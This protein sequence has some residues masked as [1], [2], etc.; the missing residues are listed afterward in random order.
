[1]RRLA[2]ALALVLTACGAAGPPD[3]STDEAVHEAFAA[4]TGNPPHDLYVTR[5]VELPGIVLV[6]TLIPDMG[7]TPQGGFVAGVWHDLDDL[8]GPALAHLGWVGVSGEERSRIALLWVRHSQRF[9]ALFE[10]PGPML[11]EPFVEPSAEPLEDGRVRVRF[12]WASEANVA[13]EMTFGPAERV[14]GA[15]GR[16]AR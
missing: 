16:I 12:L 1:M 3:L 5:P 11:T 14:F 6:G 7:Y 2:A 13:G 10:D 15:D 8:D 4:A 9:G